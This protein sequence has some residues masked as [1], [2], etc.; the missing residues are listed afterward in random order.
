METSDH[1]MQEKTQLKSLY[2]V[3]FILALKAAAI[4]DQFQSSKP[5][6]IL[7]A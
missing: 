7:N 1:S 6:N 4:Q 5:I 3:H 2:I